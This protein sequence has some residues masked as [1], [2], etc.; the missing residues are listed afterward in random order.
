MRNVRVEL[1]AER[2]D[3]YEPLMRGACTV[4]Q[5]EAAYR[6]VFQVEPL[7]EWL[8]ERGFV[9]LCSRERYDLLEVKL[10]SAL[11]HVWR[12]RDLPVLDAG[13]SGT[14]AR[15]VLT[16]AANLAGKDHTSLRNTLYDLDEDHM[17]PVAEA[18]MYAAGFLDGS[19][20][21]WGNEDPGAERGWGPNSLAREERL[22]EM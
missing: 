17:R 2:E 6:L 21:P 3:L 5:V 16:V 11:D 13:A 22:E 10:A 18:M 20:D 1:S 15:A 9:E 19:A 7:W 12:N 4:A 8:L 14:S